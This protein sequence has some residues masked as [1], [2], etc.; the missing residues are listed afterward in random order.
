LNININLSDCVDFDNSWNSTQIYNYVLDKLD[1]DLP[2]ITPDEVIYLRDRKGLKNIRI[3][4]KKGMVL[5]PC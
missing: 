5:L 2:F 3:Q 4:K 1:A